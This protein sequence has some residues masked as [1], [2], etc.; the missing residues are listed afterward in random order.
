MVLHCYG[1]VLCV[2]FKYRKKYIKLVS[3][4]VDSNRSQYFPSLKL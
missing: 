1:I 3:I 2:W 4:K